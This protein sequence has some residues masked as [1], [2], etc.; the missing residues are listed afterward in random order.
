MTLKPS[1]PTYVKFGVYED[2]PDL[3]DSNQGAWPGKDWDMQSADG[4]TIP[5]E[6][7]Y[8]T[9]AQNDAYPR[10]YDIGGFYDTA[11][12]ADPLLNTAGQARVLAGGAPLE[13]IGRSG[14]YL[15]AQQMVYRPDPNSDRGLT[16]FGAANWTTSGETEIANDVVVGLFDKGL[17]ASRP[18]DYLGVAATFIGS[19]HRVTQRIDDTII[20]QGGTGHVSSEE[21]VLE[22]NYGI[23]LAPG[24]SLIPFVQYV[25]HPDQYTNPNPTCQSELFGHGGRGAGH[26]LQPGPGPA[27]ACERRLLTR[28]CVGALPNAA[29]IPGGVGP[30]PRPHVRPMR[31]P[32]RRD[33]HRLSRAG[34]RSPVCEINDRRIL[35]A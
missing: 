23:G 12:Y 18:N 15:Q 33:G 30:A 10:G 25:S 31:G 14:V 19:N 4:A 17:F 5:V 28:L 9:D 26:Q 8:Q 34:G 1:K 2:E 7:G 6:I 21:G 32:M 29:C 27:A 20:A 35:L 13:D 3:A 16:L 11:S 24:I 22:V